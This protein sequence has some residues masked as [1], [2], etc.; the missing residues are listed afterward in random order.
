MAGIESAAPGFAR[1]RITPNLGGMRQLSAA[2]P[3]PK[4][5]IKVDLKTSGEHALTADI[6]L[7]AGISGD[8]VF[9]GLYHSL[10]PGGNHLQLKF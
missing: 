10:K 6:Q 8:F 7:P 4:G 1:V 2:M 5:E 3:H 9:K